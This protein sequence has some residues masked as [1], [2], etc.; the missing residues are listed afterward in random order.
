MENENGDVPEASQHL[1]VAESQH[2]AAPPV[3]EPAVLEGH[4]R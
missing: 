1:A 3:V 4:E 2:S